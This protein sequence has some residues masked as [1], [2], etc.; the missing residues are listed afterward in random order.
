MATVEAESSV[1]NRGVCGCR[2]LAA[3]MLSAPVML[4]VR[5]FS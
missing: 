5:E 2:L 4:T 1:R 3:L